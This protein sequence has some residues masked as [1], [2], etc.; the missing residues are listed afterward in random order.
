M[1]TAEAPSRTARRKAQTRALL[2]DAAAGVMSDVGYHDAKVQDI[3]ARADVG[4]GTFYN[5]FGS[6]EEI[7]QAL[8]AD[9]I[10]GLAAHIERTRDDVTDPRERLYRGWRAVFEYADSHRDRLRVFFGEGQAFHAFMQQAYEVF[11]ADI[12]AGLRDGIAAGVYRP[13]NVELL[14]VA[15]VGMASHLVQWWLEHPEVAVDDVVD[16]IAVFEWCGRTC[17]SHPMRRTSA[18]ETE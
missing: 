10:A 13:A 6:K 5:Y 9:T 16:E 14:A 8:T 11:A 15:S 3:A 1:L 18:R 17:R 7:F 4:T 12:E 2:L